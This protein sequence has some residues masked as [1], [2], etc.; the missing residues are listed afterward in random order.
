LFNFIS[1]ISP[2]SYED[3]LLALSKDLKIFL[4]FDLDWCHEAVLEDTIQILDKFDVKATF[5]C[6]DKISSLD[7]LRGNKRFELG[8]HP[9]FRPLL[10]DSS[11]NSSSASI[12][13]DRLMSIIPEAK[14][15]RSHSLISG[16]N[17]SALFVSRGLTHESNLKTPLALAGN[18]K[19]F[20]HN[21]GI[22]MCPFQWGDYSEMGNSINLN[23]YKQYLAVNFHPIHIFLN[24]ESLDRY[25]HTRP[26]HQNPSELRRFR[27]EGRGVRN[28]L[29]EFLKNAKSRYEIK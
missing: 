27:F 22:I 14:S 2:H 12:I 8:V 13:L 9:N 20:F 16:S 17:L 29:I 26:V 19:P 21:T 11:N 18:C 3:D 5:F 24:S 7:L 28:I 15:V 23:D 25:E 10:E 1:D 4:T 6:T